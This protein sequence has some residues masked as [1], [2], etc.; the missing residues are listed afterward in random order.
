MYLVPGVWLRRQGE[1]SEW[2]V[3]C[4]ATLLPSL[5]R[6]AGS[7]RR[8]RNS[9]GASTVIVCRSSSECLY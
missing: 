9:E 4:G 8:G 6:W 7:E 2:A 3:L 1:A 5:W